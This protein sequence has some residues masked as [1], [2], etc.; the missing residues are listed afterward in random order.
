MVELPEQSRQ[1]TEAE[2]TQL[3]VPCA[4]ATLAELDPFG[5]PF[6][7]ALSSRMILYPI[8]Y[9]LE[10]EQIEVVAASAR[11]I[12]DNGFFEFMTELDPI[13][14]PIEG[15]EP[16][17]GEYGTYD[18]DP[19]WYF[20]LDDL[21]VYDTRGRFPVVETVLV[22]ASG[23]WAIYAS[24][25]DHAVVGGPESFC[26]AIAERFPLPTARPGQRK[27]ASSATDSCPPPSRSGCS[28]TTWAAGKTR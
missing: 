26:A 4:Q 12:G 3:A 2:F 28:S 13:A 23:R 22:S 1:L 17:G 21:A 6:T 27:S 7:P 5:E 11:E 20:A 18:Q 14:A 24:H 10:T 25:E 15:R 19:A 16:R 9:A 8:N